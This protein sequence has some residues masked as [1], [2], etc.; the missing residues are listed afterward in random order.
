MVDKIKVPMPG[1]GQSDATSIDV[2]QSSEQ[3][4]TY[5]LDDGSTLRAKLIVT[6]VFRV[7]NNYDVEGNPVYIFHSQNICAVQSPE[8]LRKKGP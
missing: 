3:W 1:G 5:L 6:K 8:N 2:N 7:D 4:N